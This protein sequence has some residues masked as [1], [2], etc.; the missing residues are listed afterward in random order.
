MPEAEVDIDATLVRSLLADQHPDLSD[1]P[2]VE[3]ANGWDNVIYRLGDDLTVRL[4]RRAMAA[5]LVEHE[6][7]WLPELAVRLPIPIP[8]PVRTGEPALGYP[9]RWSVNPWLSGSIAATTPFTDPER[10]AQRLGEFI[11]ALH[12]PAPVDAPPNP[13]RGHFIGRNDEVF[14]QRVEGLSG[15]GLL[16]AGAALARWRTLTDVDPWPAPPVW[17]HAD[18][19]AA[20]VLVADGE[21]SAVIDWGDICAGDPATDLSCAWSLFDA[22]TRPIFRAAAG[23]GEHQ[24][25]DATWQRAEAWA[26]HFAVTYL[27]MSDDNPTMRAIGETLLIRLLDDTS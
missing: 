21:L 23:T 26:L 19:H 2:I 24:V 22:E 6:Q 1:R 13:F 15:S 14:T 17:L 18:C 10:E 12:V 8:A 25:D 20:N 11:A 3:L 7:R 16:D 27:A 9:W 4:P 5:V